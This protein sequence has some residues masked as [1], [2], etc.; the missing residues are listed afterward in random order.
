MSASGFEPAEFDCCE[1][2]RHIIVLSSAMPP[3]IR[4]CGVC[5]HMPG[6]Y[7]FPEVRAMIDPEHDGQE[8]WER[9]TPL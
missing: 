5:Q 9:E 6:W 1:C 4:L 8:I 3:D 2:G 7:R